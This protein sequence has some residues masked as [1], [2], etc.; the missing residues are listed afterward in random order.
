MKFSQ[1]DINNGAALVVN[2][3]TDTTNDNHYLRIR[4]LVDSGNDNQA[5]SYLTG[6]LEGIDEFLNFLVHLLDRYEV[7]EDKPK[8]AK[9]VDTQIWEMN[10]FADFSVLFENEVAKEVVKLIQEI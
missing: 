1:D 9:E 3:L 7:G 8:E 5:I 10:K 6:L 2:Y 4:E